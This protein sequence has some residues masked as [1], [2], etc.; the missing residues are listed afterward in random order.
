MLNCVWREYFYGP[1]IPSTGDCGILLF[2][3][4]KLEL[5]PIFET[6]LSNLGCTN[7]PVQRKQSDQI[8][9]KIDNGNILK[10]EL[11]ENTKLLLDEIHSITH[12]LSDEA[13]VHKIIFEII[14][15]FFKVLYHFCM[16]LFA[17]NEL[18]QY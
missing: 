12:L 5:K 8:W 4:W 9:I 3:K 2:I 7:R 17:L 10:V 11:L 6:N 1:G 16:H 18:I 13:K 14:K 15:V